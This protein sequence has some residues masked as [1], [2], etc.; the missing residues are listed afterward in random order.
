[1]G[2]EKFHQTRGFRYF[3]YIVTV[4][5]ALC[6]LPSALIADQTIS[7]L[8]P[9]ITFNL[10]A[11]CRLGE[12]CWVANYVDVDPGSTAK[13]FRC[14]DRTFD[15]HDGVDI[16]IRDR[17]VMEQ[18]V[19]VLAA[20]TGI[21]RRVRDGVE[22]TALTTSASRE[23]IVGRECGNG[24]LIDHS[25]GWETQYCHLKQRSV[26]ATVGQQVERGDELGLVG[27][28]GKTEFPHVHFT[29]RHAGQVIDPFTGRANTG[30]CGIQGLALW[31]DSAVTYEEVA[32]YNAGFSGVEPQADAIRNGQLVTEMM[33]SE[34]GMLVLWVDMFGVK[35]EDRLRFR[36]TAPDGAVLLDREQRIDRTQARR[37]A[38]SGLR[39]R[40]SQWPSGLYK[41]EVELQRTLGGNS[42]TRTRS[43][44]A[45]LG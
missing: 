35:A 12:T 13:D 33:S 32:L 21:V 19:P 22:D 14:Q 2:Q 16:A 7:N 27:L 11:K 3:L 39:R 1:M 42:L 25:D 38:F 23:A 29:V 31:R 18:G 20:A 36:I 41:G 30:G 43:V 15:K 37:F 5:G 24:V 6:L 26:R 4:S 44:K 10:P 17:R 28:S 40:A 8:P 34:V 45:Q 9:Q